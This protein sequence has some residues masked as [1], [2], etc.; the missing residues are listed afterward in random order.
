MPVHHDSSSEA[1]GTW[2][3]VFPSA[4]GQEAGSTAQEYF[5]VF[6]NPE[7]VEGVAHAL[8][9]LLAGNRSL[10]SQMIHGG[11][12]AEEGNRVQFSPSQVDDFIQTLP[13]VEISK[14][15]KDDVECSICKL[16]YGTHRKNTSTEASL[17]QRLPGEEEP[18]KPVKLSCGHIFGEW[19][20]K[21]WLLEQPASCPTCRFQFQPVVEE[22]DLPALL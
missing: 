18:E 10:I 1:D 12:E 4:A 5:D 11:G 16:E 7:E 6:S 20:I 9:S 19:C 2:F 14:L 8:M 3:R 17:D 15:E 21:S 13:R 22:D